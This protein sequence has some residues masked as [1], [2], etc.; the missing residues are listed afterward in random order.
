VLKDASGSNGKQKNKRIQMTRNFSSNS[1]LFHS[2]RNNATDKDILGAIN[3]YLLNKM[4]ENEMGMI[5]WWEWLVLIRGNL[6]TFDGS[7][8]FSNGFTDPLLVTLRAAYESLNSSEHEKSNKDDKLDDANEL[9]FIEVSFEEYTGSMKHLFGKNMVSPK[10]IE[11][12]PSEPLCNFKAES[13][14]SNISSIKDQQMRKDFEKW[15]KN[16]DSQRENNEKLRQKFI[17]ITIDKLKRN[18]SIKRIALFLKFKFLPRVK[19]ILARKK[20]EKRMLK[21]LEEENNRIIKKEQEKENISGKKIANAIRRKMSIYYKKRYY[22]AKAGFSFAVK[23]EKNILKISFLKLKIKCYELRLQS[24][25]K[26]V[27]NS[28]IKYEQNILKLSFFKF[29]LICNKL[30]KQIIARRMLLLVEKYHNNISKISFL[31][32][33]YNY[34][35]LIER[36][37]IGLGQNQ[38]NYLRRSFSKFKVIYYKYQKL[39]RA[40][41]ILKAIEK[42]QYEILKLSFSTLKLRIEE[43]RNNINKKLTRVIGIMIIIDTNN[44]NHCLRISFLKLKSIC[45]RIRIQEEIDRDIKARAL[46]SVNE[47]WKK[48]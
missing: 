2:T 27:S 5:T 33:K 44:R 39:A 36:S 23:F 11:F 46:S 29:K 48:M 26:K 7:R 1:F 47:T 38:R 15:S 16:H 34:Q 18:R 30:K 19:S 42:Y 24:N 21:E 13:N 3:N 14:N 43:I 6:S 40:R 37:K 22:F 20:D 45:E 17:D 9:S 12:I 4:N 41:I 28:T 32:L 35:K 10:P 25:A 8:P 31:K